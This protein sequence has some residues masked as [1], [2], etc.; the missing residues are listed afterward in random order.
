M[1]FCTEVESSAATPDLSAGRQTFASRF[2]NPLGGLSKRPPKPRRLIANRP[3]VSVLQ[4]RR[5]GAVDWVRRFPIPTAFL[6][7]SIVPLGVGVVLYSQITSHVVS[8]FAL[9]LVLAVTLYVVPLRRRWAWWIALVVQA[10]IVLSILWEGARWLA[11]ANNLVLL[12]LLL[13]S[14]MRSFIA[15]REPVSWQRSQRLNP[16]S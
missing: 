2:A 3:T 7:L 11:W 15:E 5:I 10:L 12:G 16:P 9:A 1:S 8:W 13:S 6:V 14:Q 4:V